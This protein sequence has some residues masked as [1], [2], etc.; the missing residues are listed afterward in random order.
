MNSPQSE[1]PNPQ[2]SSLRGF[3]ALIVTQFQ[4]A[5]SDNALKWL[6][7]SLIA[8]M[9]YSSAQRDQL[10]SIVGALF[11]ALALWQ[12]RDTEWL[13]LANHGMKTQKVRQI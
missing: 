3:W 6:V 13:L 9:N 4:G 1:I 5:F 11:I 10:V 8:G 12:M 2:P 7:I